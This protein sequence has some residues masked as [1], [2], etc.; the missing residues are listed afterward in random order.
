MLVLTR[1]EGQEVELF[2]AMGDSMGKIKIVSVKGDK[3][4]LGFDMP[5][6][7]VKRTEMADEEFKGFAE[8]ARKGVK[9]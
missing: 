1:M 6:L 7:G 4:R 8:K 2:T 5:L 9:P 3:I